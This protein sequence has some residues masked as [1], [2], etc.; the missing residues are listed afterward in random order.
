LG[1]SATFSGSPA[2]G[3]WSVVNGGGSFAGNVY[4][5]PSSVSEYAATIKY[6]VTDPTTLCSN[7]KQVSIQFTD[8]SSFCTYSQGYYGNPGGKSCV[9]DE[10]QKTTGQETTIER[11]RRAFRNYS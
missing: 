7:F 11:I 8:C 1:T 5:A 9:V 10:V 2:G 3:T 4:T 6:T